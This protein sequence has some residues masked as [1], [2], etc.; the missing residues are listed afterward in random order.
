MGQSEP[1]LR[2]ENPVPNATWLR[3]VLLWLVFDSNI[4]LSGKLAPLL[5]GLAIRTQ[6]SLVS[7][8]RP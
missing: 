4:P 8:M 2:S 7:E 5:F 3:R 6:I 1:E